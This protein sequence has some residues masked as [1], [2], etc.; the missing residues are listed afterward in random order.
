MLLRPVTGDWVAFRP[1]PGGDQAL[2][3]EVISRRS[4]F[5]RQRPGPRPEPQYI[6]AN[7][8]LVLVLTGLD[9]DFN[10][11]RIERYIV[12][13]RETGIA[14]V[15]LLTKADL[16]RDPEAQA[17]RTAYH[18]PG[19]PVH[20]VSA[21]TGYGLESLSAYLEPGKTIAMMGSS[22]SGKSTLLNTLMGLQEQRT[23][24]VRASDSRGR[25]TTPFY[26][27]FFLA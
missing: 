22:G 9:R 10:L 1:N 17:A 12:T 23:G 27:V 21:L 20:A 5:F 2:V 14:P 15:V 19:I 7:I 3:V 25:H 13:A 6:A 26:I 11:K 4:C 24:S 18:A 16:E 8:D